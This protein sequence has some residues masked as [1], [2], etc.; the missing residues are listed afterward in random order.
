MIEFGGITYRINLEKTSEL[1]VS[2]ES[3]KAG[4]VTETKVEETYDEKGKLESKVVT[5]NTY[6]KSKEFDAPRFEVLGSMFQI[7]LNF[8]EEVDDTL[9]VDRILEGSSLPFRIAFNT[10][11]SYGILEEIDE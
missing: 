10:L 3:L 2:D 6:P 8:N 4:D 7:L 9:G 11:L 5:T 1:L